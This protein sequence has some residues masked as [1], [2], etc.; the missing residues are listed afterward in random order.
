MVPSGDGVTDDTLN[1]QSTLNNFIGQDVIIF[2]PAGTYIVTDTI[3][4]PKG[5]KIVGEVW[6]Q[7]MAQGPKFG[8]MNNPHVMAQVGNPGDVGSVEIQDILFTTQGA[9]AGAVLVEWNIQ[10]SSAGSAAMWGKYMYL[11]AG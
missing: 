9:T 7:I 3:V 10:Q 6:S 1:I 2:I 5:T 11:L 8:D 4:I